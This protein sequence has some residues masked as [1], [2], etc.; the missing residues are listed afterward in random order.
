VSELPLEREDDLPVT[1]AETPT[2]CAVDATGQCYTHDR[3][4]LECNEAKDAEIERLRAALKECMEVMA[5]NGLDHD[6]RT[7]Y[8]EARAALEGK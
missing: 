2:E 3:R 5:R 4:L 8:T 6:Y 7:T 1:P